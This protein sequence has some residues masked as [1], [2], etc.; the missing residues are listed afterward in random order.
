MFSAPVTVRNIS[1]TPRSRNVTVDWTVDDADY[2]GPTSYII[3]V[4]RNEKMQT[5]PE[6]YMIEGK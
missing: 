1:V 2:V 6:T 5:N 3:K 4:Q